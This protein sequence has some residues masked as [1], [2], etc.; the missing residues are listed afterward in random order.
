MH[1]FGV[2]LRTA[3]VAPKPHWSS[4]APPTAPTSPTAPQSLK[5]YG[6]RLTLRGGGLLSSR[7]FAYAI[8]DR[9]AAITS[10]SAGVIR[11]ENSGNSFVVG[12]VRLARRV[13]LLKDCEHLDDQTHQ[14]PRRRSSRSMRGVALE[15]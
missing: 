5:P 11:I 12:V 8:G 14:T 4:A 2:A 13:A 10:N 15:I 7:L 3:C 1:K 9:G 6:Y